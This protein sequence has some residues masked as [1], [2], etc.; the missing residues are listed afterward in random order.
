MIA[1]NK[2]KVKIHEKKIGAKMRPKISFFFFLPFSQVSFMIFCYTVY[3]ASLEQC[4]TTS[5]GTPPPSSKKKGD[6]NLAQMDQ[7]QTQN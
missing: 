5:R 3:D 6:P 4:L 2:V 7:N 1:C